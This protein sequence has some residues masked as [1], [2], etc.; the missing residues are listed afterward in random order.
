MLAH[1]HQLPLRYKLA[2]AV[3]VVHLSVVACG[4]SHVQLPGVLLQAYGRLSGADYGFAFFAPGVGSEQ[5]VSFEVTQGSG[6]VVR[7][8]FR[9][10]NEAVNLRIHSMLIRFKRKN[11][12]DRMASSWAAAM[13]GRH[14]EARSVTVL[15]EE[16][17][18]PSMQAHRSG[19]RP[20]WR[21]IYRASFERR[22]PAPSPSSP[23]A[24]P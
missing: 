7:D 23:T 13:F 5:R 17:H 3:A 20:A 16:F 18:L 6:E 14:P 10:E 8:D 9:S 4:A 24:N 15:V 12:Q 22:L 2:V 11:I 21:E 19:E 1:P